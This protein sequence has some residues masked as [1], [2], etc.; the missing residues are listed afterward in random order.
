MSV[1]IEA[2]FRPPWWLAG[3]HRQSILVGLPLRRAT[4][5]RRAWPLREAAREWLIDCGDGVRLQ[6][7]HSSP[8]SVG[9]A[10]AGRLAV[11]LHGWEG[12]ADSLYVL[13]L[14]QRL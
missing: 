4:V 9:R 13:S 14:G 11:L 6:A 10:A 12:S 2:D 1:P 3:G 5:Q 8:A 7:W